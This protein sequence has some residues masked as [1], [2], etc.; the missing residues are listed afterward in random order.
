MAGQKKDWVL[1]KGAFHRLLN[2]L[3]EG[4]DSDGE[5][6]VEIRQKLVSFFDGKNCQSPYRL[7]DETLDRVARRLEEEGSITDKTPAHYCYIV[8]KYI[9]LESLRDPTRMQGSLDELPDSSQPAYNPIAVVNLNDERE[10]Q[11]KWLDCLKRCA[12]ELALGER[13]LI[14]QYYQGKGRNKIENRQALADRLEISIEELR[15][16]AFRIRKRLKPRV[17]KCV[18]R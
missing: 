10:E 8:A 3:D 18:G 13:E 5:K 7:A 12:Q 17:E 15:I 2:W 1:T 9:F 6:Y 14:T 4:T 16:R 11:E